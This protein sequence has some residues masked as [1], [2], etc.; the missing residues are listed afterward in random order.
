MGSRFKKKSSNL[1]IREQ[2]S[3]CADAVRSPP[4]T[5]CA[6]TAQTESFYFPIA[7]SARCLLMVSVQREALVF[8]SCSKEREQASG[9]TPWQEYNQ[10]D[11]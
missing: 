10:H 4:A 9:T 3:I 6:P 5:T 2:E 7:S 8:A 11:A 1:D